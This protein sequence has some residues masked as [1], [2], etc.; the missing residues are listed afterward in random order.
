MSESFNPSHFTGKRVMYVGVK[1]VQGICTIWDWNAEKTKYT[2]RTFGNK[3]YAF[4]KVNGE[5][6]SVCC[7]TFEQAKEWRD[8]SSLYAEVV[9]HDELYFADAKAKYFKH[10]KT[11]IRISTFESYESHAKHLSFFDPL[12]V[13]QINAKVVDAWIEHLKT[14][15][16]LALQH[17]S[18]MTYHHELSILKLILIYVS[19]YLDDSYQVPIKKRHY[20]D[21]VIDLLRYQQSRDRNKKRFIPRADF[22][23][24]LTE[25]WA[26]ARRKPPKTVFTILAEFQLGSGT[27]VGEACSLSWQDVNLITGEASISKTVEWSRKKGRATLISPVTKT[28]DSRPIFLSDRALQVL[29]LWKARCGWNE[30]LIFSYDGVHPICYRSAQHHFGAAFRAL[31][32]PWRSTHIL[33]HSF[34]T[35]FLEKTGDK[36]ALQGQLGHTTS[37]QT[38]HYAKITSVTVQAGVKSY[39]ESLKG[40]NVVELFSRVEEENLDRLGQ[41]GTK[42]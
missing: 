17:K 39:S 14:K 18:R 20:D 37:K 25:M 36:Q 33:R 5:Q 21:S 2:K 9:P 32:M 26:R 1:G 22:E 6:K 28:G 11:K 10:V 27:R 34:S 30:G 13:R 40:S 3:Y 4:K 41:A 23:K 12:P 15:E 35:D 8:S 29:R 24:F 19:E 16:Y 42:K 38:D 7:E 31:R